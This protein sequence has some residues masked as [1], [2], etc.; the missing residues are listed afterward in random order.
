[1]AFVVSRIF[2]RKTSMENKVIYYTYYTLLIE[3]ALLLGRFQVLG[4]S[5]FLKKLN[6]FILCMKT[7]V[8]VFLLCFMPTFCFK[9]IVSLIQLFK[10]CTLNKCTS[11]GSQ[12]DVNKKINEG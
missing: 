1:M 7:W 9:I 6:C 2:Q 8:F 12:R 3:N 10:Y 4:I 5:F 11:F